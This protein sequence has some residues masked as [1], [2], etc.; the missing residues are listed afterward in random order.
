MNIPSSLLV[1]IILG[2]ST[3]VVACAPSLFAADLGGVAI[4]GA[5]SATAAYSNEYDYYGDTKDHLD[6]IQTEI[7]LNAGYRF[8]NG[9]RV[10]AQIY[11]YEL[12]GFTR[13]TIDFA[14]LDYSFRPEIGVRLGRNK[15]MNGLYNDVQDLDQVRIFASLPLSFYPRA[16]RAFGA[17]FDGLALYGTIGA[18]GLGSFDY[19]VSIG[20]LATVSG[21]HP[22]SAGSA[23]LSAPA[24]IHPHGLYG[25]ALTW[26]PRVDGLKLIGTIIIL[27][28]VDQAGY[29]DTSA[30]A[31]GRGFGAAPAS[32]DAAFGAGV[33][34]HSGLFAGTPTT[35]D[36]R[37]TVR[38]FGAEYTRGKW[39]YAAEW[40]DERV[41][42]SSGI[43][44]LGLINGPVS[45][46]KESMYGQVAY[47]AT[48]RFGLGI[49]YAYTDGDPKNTNPAPSE[50]TTSKDAAF[51]VSYGLTKWWLI[52][53]EVHRIKGLQDL[54]IAGDPVF[55][56][57]RTTWNYFVFKSTVSF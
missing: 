49:Y 23:N 12:A 3:F 33:W 43:P 5:V 37:Y 18:G 30:G 9:L 44:A 34:D 47:Q 48:D 15:S 22:Y 25:A 45:T 13:L 36:I 50:I 40:K 57:A 54:G 7:T 46:L 52:K 16:A 41:K 11:A 31:Y 4:H 19:Q 28:D 32:I 2:C 21:D 29:L 14:G 42:G 6:L 35:V 8:E 10:G 38:S 24:A 20:R 1:T 53:A 51:A 27:P 56:T 17:S 26:N 55:P 39:I